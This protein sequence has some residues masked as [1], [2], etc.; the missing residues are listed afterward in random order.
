[1]ETFPYLK[2]NNNGKKICEIR[3]SDMVF[4]VLHIA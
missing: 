4:Y 1:M 2:H 3:K